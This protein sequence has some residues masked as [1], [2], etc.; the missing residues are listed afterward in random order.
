MADAFA[1]IENV[2][3]EIAAQ[4]TWGHLAPRKNRTYGGRVIW[5]LGCFGSDHL[6]PVPLVCEFDGLSSSPWFY[7]ALIDFLSEHSTEEGTLWRFDG[8]FRNYELRGIIK[9]INYGQH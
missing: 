7:E 6:N 9:Q 1:K 4:A 2:Y 5:A 3:R 8:T